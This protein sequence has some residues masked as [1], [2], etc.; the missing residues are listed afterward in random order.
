M[1][2]QRLTSIAVVLA[3]HVAVVWGLLQMNPELHRQVTPLLVSMITP[4][5]APGVAP[6]PPP[7]PAPKRVVKPVP[8]PITARVPPP[9]AAP[10]PLERSITID[11][12]PP[13]A[14]LPPGPPAP[15]PVPIAAAP[16]VPPAPPAPEPRVEPP[17]FDAAYLSNPVP[18]Y[19]PVARRMGEH[20][21]VLLR[22]LVSASGHPERID[23]HRSSGFERL[24][25]AA[26]EAVERW[27]FVPARRGP[28]AVAGWVI[29]PIVFTL[30][31]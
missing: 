26:R 27:Q 9:A 6:P 8:P 23:L 10:P 7:P 1:L 31:S 2:A 4:E 22:V 30:E 24:D 28:E 20:G 12:E 29:V 5:R 15:A 14:E 3:L 19:P 18:A 13:P 25:R 17:R 11:V 16:P 21:R